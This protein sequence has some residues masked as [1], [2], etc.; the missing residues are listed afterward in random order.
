MKTSNKILSTF[1][2]IVAFYF[3]FFALDL[4]LSG[5]HRD[6]RVFPDLNKHI[7]PFSEFKYMKLENVRLE[8][9]RSDSNF[10]E[11]SYSSDTSTFRYLPDSLLYKFEPTYNGDSINLSDF[12]TAH[13]SNSRMIGFN[14]CKVFTNSTLESI[15]AVNSNFRLSKFK[16]DSLN[17]I[18][19]NS[20]LNGS[21]ESSFGKL[22][23]IAYSNS[24][25]N[26]NN[27][28]F[29]D[30]LNISLVNSKAYFN[31]SIQQLS[32]TVKNKSNLNLAQVD[33]I[34]IIKEKGSK[35]YFR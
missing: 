21:R 6:D 11:V 26:A 22:N 31:K 4:R 16:T 28:Y 3:L 20:S 1:L 24:K 33:D 12:P 27:K 15:I 18:L 13:S 9:V 5:I 19:D 32:A 25:V 30:T 14:E 23:I 29:V 34:R 7:I 17:L 8:I 35:V 2:S 10:I